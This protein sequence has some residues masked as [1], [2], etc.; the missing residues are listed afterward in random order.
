MKESQLKKIKK[1]K[2]KLLALNDQQLQTTTKLTILQN[3]QLTTELEHQSQQTQQLI[4][5]NNKMKTQIESL[6]RDIEIHKEVEKEL[7]KRS[8]FCQQVIKRLRQDI[9]D[10]EDNKKPTR[11]D[12][13]GNNHSRNIRGSTDFR[14]EHT[15]T[16]DLI[17]FL[18]NKL[19]MHE[20]NLQIK[21]TEYEQL[22]S[23]Y[24]DLQEKFSQSRQKYKR[25]AYLLS[26]FLEDL[27]N[28]SPGILQPDKD[29]FLNLEKIK[30][31]PLEKLEKEDKISLVL[32]LLKQ[33]QPYLSAQNLTV[34]P[35]Q[36]DKQF[37]S[38]LMLSGKE[39]IGARNSR[40]SGSV[41]PNTTRAQR[42]QL[43]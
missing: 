12:T 26:E 39:P 36:G 20:K 24:H 14:P 13:Q 43:F 23:D 11:N 21:Q 27:I 29:L 32:V 42:K 3:Q 34:A 19:E 22:L 16:E 7:A 25:A 41:Q 30:E 17:G 33:L 6:K 31:T 1:T 40:G 5:K 4:Y 28:N 15:G 35:P 2:A 10:L 37:K 9:K 18:E 8:Q 38:P